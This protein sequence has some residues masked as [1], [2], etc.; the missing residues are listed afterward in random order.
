[1]N[2]RTFSTNPNGVARITINRPKVNAFRA[3]TC[4]ELIKAFGKA[5]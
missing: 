3:N 5:G 1:M 4:E 2:F